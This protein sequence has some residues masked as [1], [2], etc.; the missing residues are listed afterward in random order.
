[1]YEI[2]R[3]KRNV[4]SR[5][6]GKIPE[7][8]K[9]RSVFES[10]R[11][12]PFVQPVARAEVVGFPGEAGNRHGWKFFVKAS[13]RSNSRLAFIRLVISCPRKH[14]V[15]AALSLRYIIPLCSRARL[16]AT[17]VPRTLG[18]DDSFGSCLR[19]RLTVAR[20]FSL[21]FLLFLFLVLAESI[22]ITIII[23]IIKFYH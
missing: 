3:R 16:F 10:K 13:N 14:R 6:V 12:P 11:K 8:W 7:S 23:I 1:M 18:I 5:K 21:K 17:S 4:R 2:E 20:I 22:V 9:A 19:Y 15:Y